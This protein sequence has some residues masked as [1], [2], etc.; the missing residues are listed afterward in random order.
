MS[1][2]GEGRIALVTG[3]SAGIGKALAEVF[4]ANGFDLILTARRE[5]RLRAIGADLELRHR[6][7]CHV[8]QADLAQAVAPANLCQAF[9]ARGLSVDVL[10]NNAGFGVPGDFIGSNWET[11]GEFLQVM[12]RAPCEL[13]HRLL[14]DMQRKGYGRVLNVA[15]V[16]GLLPGS[17]GATLYGATKAMLIKFSQ[18]LH[19]EN[20]RYGVHVSALC[21]GFTHSEF[22]D[23]TGSRE[24]MSRMPQLLWLTS[25]EVAAAGYR[26]VQRNKSIEVPGLVYKAIVQIPRLLPDSWAKEL[27]GRRYK[28]ELAVQ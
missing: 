17:P 5:N 28:A 20:R 18:A 22:H 19:L 2:D 1:R 9:A 16:A 23:V 12:L 21:P 8:F 6:V 14:P 10:I 26:A 13:A 11:H 25:E 4:A 27:A 3:A 15:S 24:E 7:K